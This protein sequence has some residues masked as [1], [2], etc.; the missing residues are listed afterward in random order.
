MTP[1]PRHY[2]P[3]PTPPSAGAHPVPT[4]VTFAALGVVASLVM[5]VAAL[6]VILPSLTT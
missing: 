1:Q 2:A 4:A 3:I 5:V 6:V